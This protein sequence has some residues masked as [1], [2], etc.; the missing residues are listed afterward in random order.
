MKT[1][2]LIQIE[3]LLYIWLNELEKNN[4]LSNLKKKQKIQNYRRK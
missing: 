4:L 1:F 3:K 2:N